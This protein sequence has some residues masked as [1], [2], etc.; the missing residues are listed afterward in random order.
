VCVRAGEKE[1]KRQRGGWE[2]ESVRG[3]VYVGGRERGDRKD[4][5][6][7]ELTGDLKGVI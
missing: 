4:A 5:K 1:H 6:P 2:R 7:V 3:C